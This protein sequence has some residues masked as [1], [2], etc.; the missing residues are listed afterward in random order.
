[1][2]FAFFAVTYASLVQQQFKGEHPATKVITLLQGLQEEIKE[3]GQEETHLYGKFTYW[4]SE[5]IKDKEKSVKEY[6]ETISVATST[7]QAMTEDIAALESELTAIGEELEKDS[8]AKA[9]MQEERD[10]A[11][12]LYMD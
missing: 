2:S 9:N 6:E 1:M 5:T 7:I 10:S 11:N 3:E 8:A 12:T 4:G